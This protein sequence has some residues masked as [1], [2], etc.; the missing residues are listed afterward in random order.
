[1]GQGFL[2]GDLAGG[3]DGDALRRLEYVERG[4]FN[5]RRYK[6]VIGVNDR[7]LPGKDRF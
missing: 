2:A 1:V 3:V 5:V 7:S 6:Y 4:L